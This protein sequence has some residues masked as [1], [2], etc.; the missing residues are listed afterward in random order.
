MLTLVPLSRA[1]HAERRCILPSGDEA[2]GSRQGSSAELPGAAVASFPI[3]LHHFW[4][5][6]TYLTM[7]LLRSRAAWER[8]KASDV[9]EHKV[10]CG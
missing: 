10:M 3:L 1:K 8:L 2:L 4:T 7:L 6:T 5:G 9:Q